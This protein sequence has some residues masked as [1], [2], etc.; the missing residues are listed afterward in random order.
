MVWTGN[1]RR[2]NLEFRAKVADVSMRLGIPQREAYKLI[3]DKYP[4]KAPSQ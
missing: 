1:E 2:V 3:K 4:K